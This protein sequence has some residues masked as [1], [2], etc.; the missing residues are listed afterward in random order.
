MANEINAVA[1]QLWGIPMGEVYTAGPGIK[2]DN[3]HKV[4]SVDETEIWSG[5]ETV[6]SNLELTL[7]EDFTNFERI[8]IYGETWNNWCPT[9]WGEIVCS[10]RGSSGS[11]QAS[12]SPSYLGASGAA[13]RFVQIMFTLAAN[14]I[15]ITNPALF[16]IQGTA[17]TSGTPTSTVITRVVGVNRISGGN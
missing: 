4:V 2:I 7:S 3:V 13:I 11:Y 17:V 9:L 6:A 8:K 1:G 16:S 10:R 14:K 5:A 15:T 12:L